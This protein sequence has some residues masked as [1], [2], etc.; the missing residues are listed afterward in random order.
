MTGKREIVEPR[1]ARNVFE[2]ATKVQERTRADTIMETHTR[3]MERAEYENGILIEAVS[4]TFSNGERV[5]EKV[6]A[7]RAMLKN[8]LEKMNNMGKTNG[9]R[10]TKLVK[11][12][13]AELK[14]ARSN[15]GG[16]RGSRGHRTGSSSGGKRDYKK[17]RI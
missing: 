11:E 6:E 15:D 5:A 2:S 12:H 7:E 13:I 16:G 10:L 17:P 1:Q 4:R 14:R 8:L 3:R 9:G